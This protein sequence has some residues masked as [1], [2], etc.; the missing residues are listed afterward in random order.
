MKPEKYLNKEALIYFKR[1][2]KHLKDVDA[3]EDIDSMGISMMA[4][5]LYMYHN[6]AEKC[7]VDGGVQIT[8]NGY[9]QVTGYLT[10]MEKCKASFLK[11]S[12]KYGLSPKDREKMLKFINARSAEKDP[13]QKLMDEYK[14]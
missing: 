1:I 9:S 14:S 4:M 13:L 11:F 7:A 10:V 12:E 5:D 6:A 8:A 3:L 2:E